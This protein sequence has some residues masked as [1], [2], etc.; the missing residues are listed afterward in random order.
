M[1]GNTALRGLAV[2]VPVYDY[3]IS[4]CEPADAVQRRLVADTFALGL[5]FRTLQTTPDLAVFL[6]FLVGVIRPRFAVEVGTFTGHSSLSIARALPDGARLLCCD[7]SKKMTAIARRHWEAA[8]VA[9]RIDLVIGPAAETLAN[10]DDDQQVDFAFID[11]DVGGPRFGFLDYYDYYEM[12]LPRLSPH[13]MIAFHDVLWQGKVADPDADD[14]HTVAVRAF[15]D[16]VAVDP[17]AEAVMLSVGDGLTLIR[18]RQNH[19]DG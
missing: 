6:S 17:R 2:N 8:G 12:L 1:G 4:H 11:A 10:L 14:E 19:A 13:G 5:P 9:D 7:S 3:L 15:N 18:R 16:H